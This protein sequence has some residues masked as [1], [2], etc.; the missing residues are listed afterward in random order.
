METNTESH[1]DVRKARSYARCIGT[2]LGMAAD[3]VGV[4]C[5]HTWPSILLSLL[6]PFPGIIV[7]MGQLDRLL[8]EWRELG[9]VPC[10]KPLE[11]W[12]KDARCTLR[13]LASLALFTL[14]AIVVMGSAWVALQFAPHGK[15]VALGVTV[16]LAIALLPTTMA[17]M[18][19]ECSTK[20]LAS[21]MSGWITGYRHYS[22]LF[23]YQLLLFMLIL[24]V[25]FLGMLPM[26][27]ISMAS[28]KAWQATQAGDTILMPP[29]WPLTMIASYAICM[30]FT[31]A[32]I[33]IEA[34]CN[35]LFWGGIEAR[36]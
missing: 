18:E 31:L 10:R 9:Y 15:W 1:I 20:P 30:L 29:T 33:T 35:M 34:F 36:D 8:G 12:G 22:S 5:R 21:C 17:M 27:I 14:V 19:I 3:H 24:L 11:G 4:V 7:F 13:A 32:T 6:L 26:G 2:G 23:P 25:M 16:V 28:A